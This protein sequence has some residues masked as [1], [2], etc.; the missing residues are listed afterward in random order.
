MQNYLCSLKKNILNTGLGNNQ[1]SEN[2]EAVADDKDLLKSYEP[3]K[4][5]LN[6]VKMYDFNVSRQGLI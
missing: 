6:T 2:I 3:L 1:F 4:S 5:S